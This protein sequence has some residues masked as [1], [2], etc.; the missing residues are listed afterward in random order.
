MLE[1]FTTGFTGDGSTELVEFAVVMALGL[2]IVV[3]WCAWY[4]RQD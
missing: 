2:A 3:A 1:Q 4:M